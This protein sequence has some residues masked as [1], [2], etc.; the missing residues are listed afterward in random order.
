MTSIGEA[1][2]NDDTASAEA[3]FLLSS[4]LELLSTLAAFLKGSPDI[5]EADRLKT[6]EVSNFLKHGVFVMQA[7]TASIW[8]HA[9]A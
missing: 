9:V 7:D 3:D 2:D 6:F 8:Y 5:H 4:I 1:L